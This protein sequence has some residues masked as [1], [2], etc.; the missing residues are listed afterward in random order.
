MIAVVVNLEVKPDQIDAFLPLMMENARASVEAEP[1]CHQFDVSQSADDL[2]QIF[3]Y[4]VYDDAAA[5]QRHLTM[6][7]FKSFDAAVADMLTKKSVQTFE[8]IS[9]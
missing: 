9:R 8:I 6:P 1:G 4:E 5:F 7:H 3:L 2:G